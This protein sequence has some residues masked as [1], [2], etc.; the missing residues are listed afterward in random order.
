V[1]DGSRKR[2]NR[3]RAGAPRF[4]RRARASRKFPRLCAAVQCRCTPR[5][6]GLRGTQPSRNRAAPAAPPRATLAS[7]RTCVPRRCWTVASP[8]TRFRGG[9]R[10]S[11]KFPR[12]CAA[13]QRRCTTVQSS[14]QSCPASA[15]RA[16]R[17]PRPGIAFPGGAERSHHR[18]PPSAPRCT[19]LPQ[20]S[21]AFRG[22]AA[23]L[24]GG[25]VP[26]A[27]VHS[28]RAIVRRG[29]IPCAT[30]AASRKC[31][32]RRSRAPASPRTALAPRRTSLS[33]I[34]SAFHGGATPLHERADPPQTCAACASRARRSP[35]AAR[36]FPGRSRALASPRTTLAR[37]CKG[38][39]RFHRLCT[40]VQQ[41]CSVSHD[42]IT[43]VHGRRGM[44]HRAP[45]RCVVA[46]QGGARVCSL[47][48]PG[49]WPSTRP[50]T[51]CMGLPQS[52]SSLHDAAQALHGNASPSVVRDRARR[53]RTRGCLRR[54]AWTT[55][56][57]TKVFRSREPALARLAPSAS[58]PRTTA[59]ACS[60]RF[61]TTGHQFRP[62][63]VA[64]PPKQ[65]IRVS[66]MGCDRPR[67]RSTVA[68]SDRMAVARC[69]RVWRARYVRGLDPR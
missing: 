42:R 30:L 9:A 3:V 14:P 35:Q 48:R 39:P 2:I 60:V 17:S 37:R 46:A 23:P 41:R 45:T 6:T 66:A 38:R 29:C 68:F 8:R 64:T 58:K 69:G 28:P 27:L 57:P 18:A 43:T 12:P 7:S 62:Q 26:C 15:S 1:H 67:T 55:S 20:I 59:R 21:P 24:H 19:A 32:P 16:R 25:A 53:G 40:V 22:V 34:S 33:R 11:R 52:S 10:A 31:F 47:R 13:L 49:A 56:D 5:T 51:R 54:F 4:H 44:P 61:L 36:A 65:A 63:R 50:A